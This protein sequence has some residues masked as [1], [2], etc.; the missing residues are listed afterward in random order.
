[1]VYGF[2][3][4]EDLISFALKEKKI[5]IA[6]NAE[7]IL[8][9][10]ENARG[11]I[12]RNIGYADGI[13]A[14]LALQKKGCKNAVKIPGCELWL[15]SIQRVHASKSFYLI[16]A[17]EEVISETV[18]KLRS[19]YPG[20]NIAGY[21]NGYLKTEEEK[22]H[23]L[24][25]V[26]NIKPDVIFVAMGSPRQELL[27]QELQDLHPAIYQGLGGSFDVYIGRV[28]RAPKWWINNNLEFAYRMIKQPRRIFRLIHLLKFTVLLL[29]NKY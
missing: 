1:M 7:K 6:I 11:M 12:N 25:N 4:R 22:D 10:D 15:D 19:T 8:H 26:A 20:I 21:R 29:V 13:G 23:L 5:L 14:V 18:K 16:G 3:G 28:Q 17:R 2:S 24:K 9:A 27:M